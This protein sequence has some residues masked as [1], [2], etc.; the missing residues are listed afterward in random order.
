[1]TAV[2]GIDLGGTSAR[3][4]WAPAGGALTV[5]ELAREPAPRTTDAFARLVSEQAAAAARAAG[6]PVVA[7]AVTV[8]G[9]VDGTLCRWVPNLPHLDGVDLAELLAPLAVPV[10]VGHDAQIALLAETTLGACRDVRDALLV[11]VGT[12]I[13]SAVLA[14]GRI[15]RGSRGGA[16]SLGWACA[17]LTDEGGGRSGWLERQAAGRALDALGARL[18]P[19]RDGAGLVDAARAGDAEAVV[20]LRTVAA[21]L[22][23]AVA[24]AVALLDPEVVVFAGGVADAL[25]VLGPLLREELDRRLPPHLRGAQGL[26]SGEFGPRAGLVG[27]LIAARK[28]S[29]WWEADG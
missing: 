6:G 23:T 17:D 26:R 15:V 28:G 13:G 24:G 18:D 3:F 12:G 8:P 21:A 11:A 2:L 29:E 19:P 22:G 5:G 27:A 20:A 1:V 14:G 25:D 4:A 7:V 9:L 10:V 16:A